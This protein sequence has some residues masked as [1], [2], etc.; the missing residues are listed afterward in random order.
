[1]TLLGFV[2]NII[3]VEVEMNNTSSEEG[4]HLLLLSSKFQTLQ[5]QHL[6][7]LIHLKEKENPP[8]GHNF[9]PA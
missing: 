5:S 4:G 8:V 2:G 3:C 6:Q 1:M 7:D 9:S